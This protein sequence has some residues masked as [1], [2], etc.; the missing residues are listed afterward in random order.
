MP[1]RVLFTV[2]VQAV[3]LGTSAAPY[4]DGTCASAFATV[5]P[6]MARLYIQ[7]HCRRLVYGAV[8]HTHVCYYDMSD[9]SADCSPH[10]GH[11]YVQLIRFGKCRWRIPPSQGSAI[12][13]MSPSGGRNLK[14]ATLRLLPFFRFSNQVPTN[15]KLTKLK[16][17]REARSTDLLNNRPTL[18]QCATTSFLSMQS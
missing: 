18:Y 13:L 8:F 16:V 9:E 17:G 15:L 1:V 2:L 12:S 14:Y 4:G 11:T 5:I 10:L 7:V 6:A 3:S